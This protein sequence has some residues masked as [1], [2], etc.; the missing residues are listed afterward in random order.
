M[1]EIVRLAGRLGVDQ[2]NFKQC[3][4]IRD[5]AGKNLG[6]FAPGETGEIRKLRLPVPPLLP[7]NCRF[8]IRIRGT[9]FS[10]LMTVRWHHASAL[11]W[12]VRQPFWERRRAWPR[13][14]MGACPTMTSWTYGRRISANFTVID[15][16]SASRSMITRLSGICLAP[17]VLV[18]KKFFKPPGKRCLPRRGGVMFVI[19]STTSKNWN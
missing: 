2:V 11:L 17:E 10:L 19:I 16:W 6:L 14:T 15:L 13:Y 7:G 4:V 5:K 12:E 8:V 1:E 9:L 18:V 3:D